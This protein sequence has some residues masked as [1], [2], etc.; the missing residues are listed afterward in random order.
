MGSA[1][2]ARTGG[3]WMAT[4]RE[5]VSDAAVNV[6]PYV[7][8]AMKDEE[9]RKSVKSAFA[10]AKELYVEL[11]DGKG[12]VTHAASKIAKDKDM[13]E[14]LRKAVEELRSASKRLKGEERSGSGKAGA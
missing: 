13:Q 1:N 11:A 5:K 14:S 12:G 8:R 2:P 3:L 4:A 7:E 6:K 9:L 10:A